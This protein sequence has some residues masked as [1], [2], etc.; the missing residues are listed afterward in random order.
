MKRG[1]WV[2]KEWTEWGHWSCTSCETRMEGWH[3]TCTSCGNPR[4]E[5]E[6]NAVSFSSPIS[7]P[8]HQDLANA[9][10]DWHCAYC[11]AGN[12]GDGAKCRSCGVSRFTENRGD[13]EEEE[14]RELHQPLVRPPYTPPRARASAGAPLV[15]SKKIRMNG[16]VF[17]APFVLAGIASCFVAY[18]IWWAFQTH[19]VAGKVTGMTW[20]HSVI[21]ENWQAVTRQDWEDNL[22]LGPTIFP[23]KGQGE[24]AGIDNIRNCTRKH[25]HDRRY[26]CGTERVCRPATRQVANG[27]TCSTSCSNNR[28][29]SRNCRQ[30]CRTRYRSESYTK[31]TTETKYCT[32]P[33]YKDWCSYD[34]WMW[35]QTEVRQL[36][37]TGNKVRWPS[38]DVGPLDRWRKQTDYKV[39][40]LYAEGEEKEQTSFSPKTELEYVSWAPGM[41][42]EVEVTNLG[43]TWEVRHLQVEKF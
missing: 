37:G 26:T 22:R 41:G 13:V 2:E 32:E 12:R 25:H 14:D 17:A 39:E 1:E 35:N 5:Q 21:V 16:A 30:V 4:E 18:G 19:L 28:N 6:L 43:T 38:T 23:V 31:C 15:P 42:A 40:V 11:Q 36:T 20:K 3:K 10:A 29:G 33:I 8:Q 27:Q 34:T 7:A 24:V 9:G